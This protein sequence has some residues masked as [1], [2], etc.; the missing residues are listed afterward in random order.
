M[1]RSDSNDEMEPALKEMV[2][3][4]GVPN[5]IAK[6]SDLDLVARVIGEKGRKIGTGIFE[7]K[8][9]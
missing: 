6:G 8:V 9:I 3:I 2:E 7:K 4:G 1:I 5:T